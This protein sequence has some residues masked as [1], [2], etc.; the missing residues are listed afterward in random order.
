MLTNPS[1]TISQFSLRFFS[2]SIEEIEKKC[3]EIVEKVISPALQKEG[4]D[5]IFHGIK[6]KC[7]IITLEGEASLCKCEQ[8]TAIPNEV[9]QAFQK[10]FPEDITSIR[11]KLDFED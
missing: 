1:R 5:I 11:Q 6:D 10:C 3:D 7:A 8:C 9:L 2:K 4:S